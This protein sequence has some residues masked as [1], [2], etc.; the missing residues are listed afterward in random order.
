MNATRNNPGEV[1]ICSGCSL[2]SAC[3]NK[4]YCQLSS[5]SD[6]VPVRSLQQR[7]PPGTPVKLCGGVHHGKSGVVIDLTKRYHGPPLPQPSIGQW[8][9]RRGLIP[10][11]L[12]DY[13]HT[14]FWH[15]APHELLAASFRRLLAKGVMPVTEVH[16]RAAYNHAL[17]HD[18]LHDVSGYPG[19]EVAWRI[20]QTGGAKT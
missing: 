17:E 5:P 10:V 1:S 11:Y 8:E 15:T 7:W 20:A 2:P 12:F 16:S 13:S 9:K 19:Y 6:S 3:R 18:G 4:G 14:F